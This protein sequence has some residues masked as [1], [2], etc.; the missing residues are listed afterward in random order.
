MAVPWNPARS[1]RV[2]TL[3]KEY[4]VESPCAEVARRLL[5]IARE[6]TPDSAGVIIRANTGQARYPVVNPRGVRLFWF[7]H[8]AVLVQDHCVD[9]LTGTPGTHRENYFEMHFLNAPGDLRF[10]EADPDLKDACL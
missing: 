7:Y 4:T 1:I 2:D 9:A 10:D 6:E 3:L 5:P 8:V